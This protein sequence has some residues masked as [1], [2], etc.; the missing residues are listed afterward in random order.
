MLG[1]VGVEHGGAVAAGQGGDGVDLPL[2]H[3]DDA[4]QIVPAARR[5]LPLVVASGDGAATVADDASAEDLGAAGRGGDVAGV[6]ALV[7]DDS[8]VADAVDRPDDAGDPAAAGHVAGVR[9]V[10]DV[11]G[12][13]AAGVLHGA[14]DAAAHR[15]ET[16]GVVHGDRHRAVHVVEAAAA[17]VADHPADLVD[18]ADSHVERAG[19]AQVGDG[20]AAD[21]AEE[22]VGAGPRHGAGDVDAAD[23]VAGAVEGAVEVTAGGHAVSRQCAGPADRRPGEVPQ[24]DVACELEEAPCVGGSRR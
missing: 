23:R 16:G 8:A 24:V 6:E 11:H 3:A 7:H 12:V 19:D 22:S 18:R 1:V 20:A 13:A 2:Q 4:G 21:V 5:H 9:A 14:G 10:A 17:C 15:G